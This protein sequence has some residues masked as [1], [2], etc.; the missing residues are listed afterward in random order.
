MFL[1][2]DNTGEHRVFFSRRDTR[3]ETLID[4]AQVTDA[5]LDLPESEDPDDIWEAVADQYE[6]LLG[7]YVVVT[8]IPTSTD[9]PW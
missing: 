1:I 4:H 2:I 5:D 6:E 3:V 9:F 8:E 7:D